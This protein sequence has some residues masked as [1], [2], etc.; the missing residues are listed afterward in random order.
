V[1]RLTAEHGADAKLPDLAVALANCDLKRRAARQTASAIELA[2]LPKQPFPEPRGA[3]PRP[4]LLRLP[5][6]ML[7]DF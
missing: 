2:I 5:P 6:Q 3:S 7:T 1:E 4:P